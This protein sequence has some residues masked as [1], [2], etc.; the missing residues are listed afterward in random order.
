MTEPDDMQLLREYAAG[1]S[2]DAF[3]TLVQRHV[4]LVYSVALRQLGDAHHAQDVA[5][6]VFVILARKAA[7]LR[8]ETILTAGFIKL[9]GS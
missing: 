2:E 9:P 3:A 1:N 4:N 7:S 6:A 8:R 5:Q